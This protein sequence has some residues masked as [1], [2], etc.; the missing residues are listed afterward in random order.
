[1]TSVLNTQFEINLN[2]G[3]LFTDN[4]IR[5]ISIDKKDTID[6]ILVQ[7]M[8]EYSSLKILKKKLVYLNIQ[9]LINIFSL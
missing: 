8:S 6:T 1:M 5:N 9:L 4:E 2:P 3:Q 7:D